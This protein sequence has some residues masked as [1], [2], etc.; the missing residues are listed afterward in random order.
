ML[1]SLSEQDRPTGVFKRGQGFFAFRLHQFISGAGI[2]YSTLEPAPARRVTTNGQQFLPEDASKRLYPVHFCRECGQEYHPVTVEQREGIKT[3][4][5]REIDDVPPQ[6]EDD[7]LVQQDK[8]SFG[9]V[10][11]QPSDGGLEF[12]DRALDYPEDWLEPDTAGE[13]RLKATRRPHRAER[14][15]VDPSGRI[16]AGSAAWFLPGKFRFCLSCK[17][18]HSAQGKDNNRLASLSAEGRSSATTL[19]THSVLRWMGR[20]TVESVAPTRQKLLGFTDN[21]QDAALQ[22]GH[23]NDFLF[24]SLLRAGM[25]GATSA[26]ADGLT[27]DRFGIAISK[28]LG[29]DRH[30][31]ETRSEWL[32]DPD[33]DGAALLQAQRTLRELLTYRAWFDQRKGWRFNSP[34][35]EQLGLV[36]I[37]YEGLEELAQKDDAFAGAPA[38]LASASPAARAT[39]YRKLF[40][41]LRQGLALDADVL[42]AAELEALKSRA[43]QHRS[44]AMGFQSGR[45]PARVSLHVAHT[46]SASGKH[47]VRRRST[48][49]WWLSKSAWPNVAKGCELGQRRSRARAQASRL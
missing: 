41:A 1:A 30:D 35:L 40:D 32:V 33:L 21:R 24:V 6:A 48:S 36:E 29:F 14:I 13:L 4:L 28:A 34:N 15:Q 31:K 45:A 12:E 49:S 43:A 39:A 47:T 18:V 11:V 10:L 8:P 19:F 20:Q 23:F 44:S 22:A 26:A 27:S 37:D 17:T 2:A 16:G 38:L 42:A 46:S 3:V 7:E 9:F 25:L 5:P